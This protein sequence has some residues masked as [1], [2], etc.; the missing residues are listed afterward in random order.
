MMS[1]FA[2]GRSAVAVL[3]VAGSLFTGGILMA[4][5]SQAAVVTG[6]DGKTYNVN[7]WVGSR[8]VPAGSRSWSRAYDDCRSFY[9]TR[10][11]SVKKFRTFM[12]WWEPAGEK[13]LLDDYFCST[14]RQP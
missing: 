7:G 13:V 9:G 12:G 10:V 14:A 1:K 5:Q 11:I 8:A 4:T 2:R 6:P 3:A